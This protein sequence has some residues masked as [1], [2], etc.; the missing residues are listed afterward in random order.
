METDDS[1]CNEH[2]AMITK[3]VSSDNNN[4]FKLPFAIILEDR[5]YMSILTRQE[6]E[7]LVIDLYNQGKTVRE[8]AKEARMSFRDIGVI[9]KKVVE[10][11]TKE[12]E[13]TKQDDNSGEN[14]EQQLS[15][16]T[17]AYKLFCEGTTPLEVA[18]KLNLRESEATKFYREYW[19]LNHLQSLSIVYEE[20]KDDIE[21]LLKF[22][23]L[24]KAKGM[25]VQQMVNI[26][27]VAN[28]DLPS[29][30]EQFKRLR[31]DVSMLL[32]QKYICQRNLYQLN[33]QIAAT[34]KLLNSL[35]ISCE[36][37]RREIENLYNEK[38][39]LEAR[40]TE[41]VS[42]NEEYYKIKQTAEEKVKDILTNSK[43]LLRFATFA[44]IESL[45]SNSELCNFII[46]DNS[47]NTTINYGSNYLPLTLSW[48]QQLFNDIYTALIL[49]CLT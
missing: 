45:R 17:E 46:H 3:S 5:Q 22:Y 33:N 42:N 11:K 44:V 24:S 43:L 10:E 15:L 38:A 48:Q 23:K 49:Y 40:I 13:G 4:S 12:R 6:R 8:I 2:V 9:L 14:R 35:R 41:F 29:I 27:S 1:R 34:T 30:E 28:N 21:P 19:K 25:T 37:E 31:N 26:L 47:N 7:R 16:S 39:K 18:I 36:G 20:I 32:S